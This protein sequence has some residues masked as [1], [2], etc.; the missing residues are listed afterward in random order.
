MKNDEELKQ[1]YREQADEH[2]DGYLQRGYSL[3]MH[4]QEYHACQLIKEVA[5]ERGFVIDYDE[6]LEGACRGLIYEVRNLE[7]A[8]I[9]NGK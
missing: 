9:I 7:S 6:D 2:G 3:F 4:V 8:K 1:A 5:E